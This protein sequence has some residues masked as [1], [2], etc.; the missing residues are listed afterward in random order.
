MMGDEAMTQLAVQVSNTQKAALLI[1]LLSAV[2]FVEAV[3]VINDSKG[4]EEAAPRPY[5]SLQHEQMLRE[6]AAFD[7]MLPELRGRY[8]NEFIAMA[9]QQVVD[10]DQDEIA[11]ADRVHTRFPDALI[12]IRPVLDQ[13]EPP[14]VFRSPRFTR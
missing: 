12:L 3:T 4:S 8:P 10:H 6:E 5:R 9:Q 14:L 11:L 2:D 1:E 7:A 13:P